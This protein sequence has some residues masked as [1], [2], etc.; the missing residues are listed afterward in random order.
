MMACGPGDSNA[1]LRPPRGLTGAGGLPTVR[2]MNCKAVGVGLALVLVLGAGCFRQ[3][4]RTFDIR[5]PQM[6]TQAA[7]EA[8][9]RAIRQ[10]D[11]NVVTAV[12]TDLAARTVSV[13]YNSE[14]AA[15]RNFE[16]ALVLSGFDANDLTADPA[17][18][19]Q[20]PPEMQ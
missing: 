2:G 6:K 15:R 3:V 8:V 11:T 12:K 19:A 13:T 14:R 16:Q 4:V 9:E 18:K 10:F 1:E 5:V 20:L 7:A 17:R